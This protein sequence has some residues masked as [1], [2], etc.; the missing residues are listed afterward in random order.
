MKNEAGLPASFFSKKGLTNARNDDILHTNRLCLYVI[1]NKKEARCDVSNRN[2][3][4]VYVHVHDAAEGLLDHSMLCASNVMPGITY[5]K[6][7]E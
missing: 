2:E 3:K 4:A 5:D 1:S 6:Q 7:I